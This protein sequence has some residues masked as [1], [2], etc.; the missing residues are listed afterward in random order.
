[1]ARVT[2]NDNH[3][4]RRRFARI[5]HFLRRR[6]RPLTGLEAFNLIEL[7]RGADPMRWHSRHGVWP[8]DR[9]S[10]GKPSRRP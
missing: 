9:E 8:P 10:S 7:K 3:E 6:G 1:M 2:A 5:R 4:P